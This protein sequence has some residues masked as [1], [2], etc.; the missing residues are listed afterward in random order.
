MNNATPL[1]D[2][3]KATSGPE[4]ASYH[5]AAIDQLVGPFSRHSMSERSESPV[6][7]AKRPQ[8]STS[9]SSTD[10]LDEDSDVDVPNQPNNDLSTPPASNGSID[11]LS[12][13][14]S[15]ASS[16]GY[17]HLSTEQA[18]NNAFLAGMPSDH[19][20][21][22]SSADAFWAHQAKQAGPRRP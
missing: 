10:L 5:D 13:P 2:G 20:Q 8:E 6:K 18:R 15:E 16:T 9:A 19:Q 7:Q 17:G 22:M 21:A 12:E 14:A 4:R 3:V 11:L 1:N